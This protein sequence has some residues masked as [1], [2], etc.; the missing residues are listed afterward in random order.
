[1]PEWLEHLLTAVGGGT[2][3]LVGILTIFKGL[4]NEFQEFTEVKPMHREMQHNILI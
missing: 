4:L 3:V 1:M 2:V